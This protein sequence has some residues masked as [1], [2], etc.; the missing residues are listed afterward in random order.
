MLEQREQN[1][2]VIIITTD[3]WNNLMNDFGTIGKPA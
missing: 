2:L 1:L 3:E